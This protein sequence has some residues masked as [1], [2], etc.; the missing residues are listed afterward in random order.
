MYKLYTKDKCPFCVRAKTALTERALEYQ[1][2]EL[3]KDFSREEIKEKFPNAKTY[4]IILLDDQMIGGYDN[5][6]DHLNSTEKS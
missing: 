3:G 4:P 6:M 5:L 1:S 2:F